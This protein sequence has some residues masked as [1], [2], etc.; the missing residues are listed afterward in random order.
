MF[1]VSIPGL[2][3]WVATSEKEANFDSSPKPSTSLA[4]KRAHEDGSQMECG[5]EGQVAAPKK[6]DTKESPA[7]SDL[8]SAHSSVLSTEYILNSPIADRPGKACMAKVYGSFDQFTLNEIV[9]VTGFLSVNPSLDGTHIE[10]NEFE[11]LSEIQSNNPPPSLVPRLHIVH[12][13]ALKH[14]NPLLDPMESYAKLTEPFAD[15]INDILL[16]LTQCLLGD[17]VA[18]EF[19]LCHLIS[20]VYVVTDTLSLGHFSLNFSNMPVD[21]LPEYTNMLYSVL[22]LLMPVSHFLPMTLENLN[23]I[24]FTPK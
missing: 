24:Q 12:C 19:L 16:V 2:N 23:S 22:E 20:T 11:N 8:P 6:R 13:R 3:E 15:T 21:V 7:E 5:D 9:E 14:T 4:V 1:L 18:A 17:A 10:A